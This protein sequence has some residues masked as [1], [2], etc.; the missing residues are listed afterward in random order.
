MSW[1]LNPNGERPAAATEDN[2]PKV[3][4]LFTRL[5]FR[6][7]EVELKV[8]AGRRLLWPQSLNKESKSAFLSV[9]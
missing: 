6:V 2:E 7:N 5:V 4:A 1:I 8:N 9:R 3:S